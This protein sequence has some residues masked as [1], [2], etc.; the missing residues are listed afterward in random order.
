[1]IAGGGVS[2]QVEGTG[3]SHGAFGK[4]RDQGALLGIPLGMLAG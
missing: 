4:A 2:G 3:A 1:M